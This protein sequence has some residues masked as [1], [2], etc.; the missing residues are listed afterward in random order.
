MRVTKR[1]NIALRVLMFCAVRADERITKSD[2]AAACNASEHHLGQIVN[3]LAQL[4][5]LET[6][7][8]RY[9]GLALGQPATEIRVGS[10]FR[11]F[12]ENVLLVECF[13]EETNT[14]PLVSCCR[15]RDALVAAAEAFYASLDGVSLDD[16]VSGNEDLYGILGSQAA[17]SVA[18]ACRP[19]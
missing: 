17:Q 12:E 14:C 18:V 2:I 15:L 10:I 19:H 11:A 3:R 4:G 5:Y 1:S 8:G 7:R 6:R 13:S 16:L 9:G